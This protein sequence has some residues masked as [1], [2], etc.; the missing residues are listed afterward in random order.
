MRGTPPVLKI[1]VVMS[2]VVF[3]GLL[4]EFSEF[5]YCASTD[6][7]NHVYH[8]LEHVRL[9]L[10]LDRDTLETIFDVTIK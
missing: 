6:Y 2:K 8:R 5:L 4:N 7:H 10:P 3:S 9:C 1:K